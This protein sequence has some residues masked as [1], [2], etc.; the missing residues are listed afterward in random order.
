MASGSVNNIININTIK[1]PYNTSFTIPVNLSFNPSYV[2][3]QID[4]LKIQ[5]TTASSWV[6]VCGTDFFISNLDSTY[7]Y[8]V[9]SSNDCYIGFGFS[10]VSSSRFVV[11]ISFRHSITSYYYLKTNSNWYAFGY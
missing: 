8:R 10:S 1:N 5:T 6:G 4:T 2:F 9:S 11:N 3:L 7:M